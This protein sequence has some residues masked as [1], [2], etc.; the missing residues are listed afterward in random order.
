[1]GALE[2]E[3]SESSPPAPHWQ[4]SRFAIQAAVAAVIV[5]IVAA[6]IA[7]R[8]P[9]R[10]AI[11]VTGVAQLTSDGTA[12]RNLVTDGDQLYFSEKV[13]GEEVLS[14]VAADGGPIRRIA[15]PIPNP[16]PQDISPDSKFLLVLSRQGHE[17]EHQMWIV[18]IAGGEP[19]QMSGISSQAASWSR[20]GKWIAYASGR[21]IY[22]VSPNG[23]QSYKLSRLNGIPRGL[24]WSADGKHLLV[25]VRKIPAWTIS[26]WQLNFDDTDD[27]VRTA[28]PRLLAESCCQP[29]YLVRGADGYFSVT[30]QATGDQRLAY[31]RSQKWWEGRSPQITELSTRLGEVDG[32]AADPTSRKIYLLSGDHAHGELVRYDR[33][34]QSFTM[35]LPGVGATFVDYA[36]N[37]GLIAYTK[38]S[39]N[40]LWLSRTDG[41]EARQLSPTGMNVELP[42]W[43]PD[44]KWIAF[45]G[46]QGDRAWR[47]FIVPAIGGTPEE[48][49]ESDDDQGAPTWSPDGKSLVYGNVHCQEE[50]T[51][52]IHKI[53]L[54]TGVV[55]VIPDSRGLATARWSPD[56]RYIAALN[57]VRREVYVFNL[58]HQ[59]WRRLAGGVNGDDLNW[60]S[61]SRYLY[62]ASS[63]SGQAEILR[64]P[65][66]IGKVEL[67]LNL[68]SL[69]KSVGYLGPWFSLTPGDSIILNRWLDG[70]EIYAL[71]YRER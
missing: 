10:P 23:R 49:S 60:S 9:A 39:D 18:P 38:P 31:L 48:A 57:P 46:K 21:T 24:R 26:M 34:S 37:S 17:E 32:L 36:K 70:S 5:L 44:S 40:S 22:V 63:M 64:V 16:E 58:A 50:Q 1:V 54:K 35:V 53:D 66:D 42:R 6:G 25:L 15:L 12:K 4:I 20:N 7:W 55:N 45:M 61:D 43:S 71:S 28:S 62:A 41:S 56:G 8:L 51:C 65:I 68:D 30:N 33:A 19:R 29:D 3:S 52:A 2:L 69:S 59:K 11:Q 14:T 13:G 47:I 67:V 27:A